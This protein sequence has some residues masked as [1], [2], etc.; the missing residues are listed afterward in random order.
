MSHQPVI[1]DQASEA[2]YPISSGEYLEMV[3]SPNTSD[4]AIKIACI[5]SDKKLWLAT[6]SSYEECKKEFLQLLKY[7]ALP[8]TRTFYSLPEAKSRS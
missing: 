5:Y 4:Y 6:Y 7:I 8:E 2:F 3:C 1:V